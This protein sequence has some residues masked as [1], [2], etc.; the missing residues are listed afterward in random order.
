M[1]QDQR[2]GAEG[3]AFGHECGE[4]IAAAL[5]ALKF[6]S[7]S[8]ECLLNGERVVIKCARKGTTQVGVLYHMLKNLDAVIGAFEQKDGSY[9]ILRLSAQ[10]YTL[11]MAR[12]RS[13]GASSGKVGVVN[14]SVF[15]RDGTRVKVLPK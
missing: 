1:P 3:N 8:N 11:H 4:K 7:T 13:K 10:D 6:T 5:G 14:R 2:S 9:S 15:L 12:T